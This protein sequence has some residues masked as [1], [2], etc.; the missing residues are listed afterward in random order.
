MVTYY[1]GADVHCNS[2]N[3]S[4]FCGCRNVGRYQVP[5]TISAIGGV[6]DEFSGRK[7]LTFEEG[8]MAGWL[9]RNL[10]AKTDKIVVC[11]PRRNKYIA[12]DG[13]KDDLIDA[14][15]LAH[16]LRGGYLRPVHQ[17]DNMQIVL[18]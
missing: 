11:D 13:D 12:T 2:T 6:L 14:D 3:L 16:L 4:V 15:K 18:L 10:A 1:I 5:T 7:Y 8:P 17:N 9:Y